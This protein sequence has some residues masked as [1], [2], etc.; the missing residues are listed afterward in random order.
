MK[1]E[2]S[3][4]V[5]SLGNV[6][7]Y[8]KNPEKDKACP[9]PTI[10]SYYKTPEDEKKNKKTTNTVTKKDWYYVDEDQY[11]EYLQ[12]TFIRKFYFDGEHN[13]D[14]DKKIPIVINDIY[15]R[16][17]AVKYLNSNQNSSTSLV[18]NN[19]KIIVTD[20]TGNTALTELSLYEYLQGVLYGTTSQNSSLEYLKAQAIVAKNYLYSVNGA[21]PDSMP[22]TLRIRSCK[23]NQVYCSVE[24]GCHNMNDGNDPNYD[25]NDTIAPGEGNG[26]YFKLPLTDV[27]LMQKY[28]DAIDATLY[29]F[30]VS[31]GNFVITGSQLSETEVNEM[32]ENGSTY[33]DVLSQ[34][35]NGTIEEVSLSTMAYPLDL[36]YNKV[37]SAYGWRVHPIKGYCRTHGGTDIAAPQGANIYSIADGVV[38]LVANMPSKV[39]GYG[40]YMIIG[41]GQ[42]INGTYEYYSLYAHQV[43]MPAL[44]V[45]TEVKAGKVIGNVGST[46]AST[47][48]HLHIEV[49]TLNNGS[50]L[51]Q[52]P[53]LYFEGVELTGQ[54]GGTLYNSCSSCVNSTGTS[55]VCGV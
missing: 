26:A 18:A 27:D 52:D 39:N 46:G 13:S 33:K 10:E 24:E 34:T 40:Y 54:V 41:H 32:I 21:T 14:V 2:G 51:R 19:T 42:Y 1:G 3:K 23:A 30:I 20:C 8:Y 36:V 9:K 25:S 11:K 7:A 6:L 31:D 4:C 50:K 53:V 5:D 38:V 45:G 43:R 29:D 16:V 28:K 48:P 37:T 35:Y 15:S 44:T 47:G 55:N 12:K 22:T 49:Y 17:E